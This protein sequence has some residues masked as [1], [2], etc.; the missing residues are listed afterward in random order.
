M[1]DMKEL[2]CRGGIDE[3]ILQLYENLKKKEPEI[4]KEITI[5]VEQTRTFRE[6]HKLTPG[7]DWQTE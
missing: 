6:E 2:V 7:L 4:N 5:T 1:F 3:G